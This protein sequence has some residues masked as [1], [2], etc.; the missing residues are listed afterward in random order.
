MRTLIVT[1]HF[2]PE[3]TAGRFRLQPFVEELTGRGHSVDVVCAMPNHPQGVIQEG[4]RGRAVMRRQVGGADVRYVWLLARPKK[5]FWTRVGSYASFA[6]MAS[7]VGAVQRRPDVILASSPPLPVGAAGL[8]LAKRHRVPWVLDVRDVWPESAVA[9]GELTNPRAIAQAE[10]LE[11]RLY[12]DAAA[13]VTVNDA[14]RREIAERAP[15]GRRIEV[16]PNGTTRE[17]LAAGD[18]EPD[19]AAL[20]LPA[21]RFVWT[22]AGNIGLAHGLETAIEAARLLGEDYLL[23]VIGDGPRRAAVQQLAADRPEL[24]RFHEVMP[25]SEVARWLRASDALLVSERQERSVASKLYD[26]AAVGRPIVAACRG[27]LRR[28]VEAAGVG[29]TVPHGEAAALADAIRSLRDDEVARRTLGERGPAF[30]REHLR[31]AQA[32]R[33]ADLLAEVA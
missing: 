5:T 17:W 9:L 27:E 31:E 11:R 4:Y 21:E 26:Y 10:R 8:L 18:G 19:R 3:L 6:A 22:Y 7:L 23:V 14:F 1:Q 16:I 33:L 28:V 13:V 24:V 12:R 2:A 20:G 15:T 30:A 29:V 25:P 32:S